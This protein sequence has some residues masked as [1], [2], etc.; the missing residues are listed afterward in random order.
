MTYN[1]TRKFTQIYTGESE[2]KEN[3]DILIGNAT[4]VSR[5]LDS[6]NK[7]DHVAANAT[8]SNKQIME[9]KRQL[10]QCNAEIIKMIKSGDSTGCPITDLALMKYHIPKFI[11]CKETLEEINRKLHGNKGSLILQISAMLQKKSDI[12]EDLLLRKGLIR[13]GIL[14][15]TALISNIKSCISSFPIQDHYIQIQ[16]FPFKIERIPAKRLTNLLETKEGWA[17]RNQNQKIA[18]K[19]Y[20][21]ND[22]V[23]EWINGHDLFKINSDMLF[24]LLNYKLN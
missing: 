10:R 14:A 4:E 2:M 11:S 23:K 5:L 17:V 15:E 1:A 9:W 12:S 6:Y 19:L 3:L 22:E 8:L 18:A 20:V 21:G 24:A 13:L 16:L 7:D